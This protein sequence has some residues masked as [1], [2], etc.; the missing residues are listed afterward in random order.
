MLDW[1]SPHKPSFLQKHSWNILHFLLSLCF[2]ACGYFHETLDSL[3][4]VN[5][6]LPTLLQFL[7][8][9][10]I[11]QGGVIDMFLWWY[12]SFDKHA[13]FC[14]PSVFVEGGV[15]K[16]TRYDKN[17]QGKPLQRDIGSNATIWTCRRLPETST[18][19]KAIVLSYV[20]AY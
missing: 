1:T 12:I 10:R 7:T 15:A 9:T 16:S 11:Q 14:N 2:P 13:Y 17:C 18:I 6:S 5:A 4:L 8:G 19:A 3:S 20:T